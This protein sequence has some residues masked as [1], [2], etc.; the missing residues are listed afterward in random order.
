M[1]LTT[2]LTKESKNLD[3]LDA[4]EEK[5]LKHT[6]GKLSE[7]IKER[8]TKKS[9]ITKSETSDFSS[10]FTRSMILGW[11]MGQYHVMQSLKSE[12]KLADNDIVVSFNEAIDALKAKVPIESSAYRNLDANMK[13]KAFTIASVVGEESVNRVK[14]IYTNALQSGL[15]KSDALQQL[16]GF[17]EKA[18]VSPSN[19][20]YLD[21]HYRNN[22]MSAYNTGRWTQVEHNDAVQYLM[23]SA[24]RDNGTT[25]LCKKLDRIVKPKTDDFWHKYYPPNHHKCRSIVMALS[26]LMYDKLPPEDKKSITDEEIKSDKAMSKEHQFKS[27]PTASL[28]RIP[29]GLMSKVEQFDLEPSIVNQTYT[30]NKS[31]VKSTLKEAKVRVVPVGMTNSAVSQY[32]AAPAGTA[33]IVA[34]TTANAETVLY[35]LHILGSTGDAVAAIWFVTWIDAEYASVVRVNAYSDGAIQEAKIMHKDDL[36]S[37]TRH[38][39]VI[40]SPS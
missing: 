39:K 13:L 19:P 26:Q 35:G 22:M 37:L 2:L 34:E 3:K 5:A 32:P 38:A 18:G 7:M 24:V 28:S 12:I 1:P 4:V 15:S 14:G 36:A 21:L 40:E 10:V 31:V 23:Y 29:K 20:Y 6:A 11:L 25:A 8:F 27:S 16:D 17:L 33:A 9:V 30:Q